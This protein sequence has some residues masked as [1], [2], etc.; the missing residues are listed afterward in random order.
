MIFVTKSN[1]YLAIIKLLEPYIVLFLILQSPVILNYDW[2]KNK[3]PARVIAYMIFTFPW[4]KHPHC[5]WMLFTQSCYTE[6]I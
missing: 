4:E 6:A 1:Y 3:W 5:K 2:R